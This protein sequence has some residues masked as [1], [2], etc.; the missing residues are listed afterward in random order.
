M[1]SPLVIDK[2]LFNAK[3]QGLK[4]QIRS[5]DES[6]SITEKLTTD[7]KARKDFGITIAPD[8]TRKFHGLSDRENEFITSETILCRYNFRYCADRYLYSQQDPGEGTSKGIDISVLWPSQERALR[9]IGERQEECYRELKRTAVDGAKGF[10]SGI[11]SAWHKT[12]QQGAT[13]F[14]RK[15]QAHRMIFKKFTRSIAASLDDVKKNEL[16]TRDKIWYDNL[17]FWFQYPLKYDVKATQLSLE[18]IESSI[19]YQQANQ[20][21]GVGT[22]Q[23]FDFVHMTE[24]GLWPN[25]WRLEFDLIPA[26]PNSVNTMLIWESTASGRGDD[27]FWYVFTENIRKKVAGYGSWLYIFT[28]C[29]INQSKNRLPAPDDWRPRE[30]TQDYARLVEETSQEWAGEK[31]IPT[32]HHLYWWEMEYARNDEQGTLAI[33]F[34]NFPNTPE[35][36]FQYNA[37]SALPVRVIESMRSKS[38]LGMPYDLTFRQQNRIAI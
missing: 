13:D 5:V 14:A 4:F 15:L 37:Q 18:N 25:A 10:T 20:Q 17:P 34:S 22:S 38:M 28:P 9:L 19:T 11:R 23:Q 7:V 30:E 21:S 12:R 2:L 31:I 8:G 27:N 33:F 16:Y 24:V 36:S 6:R 1:Y 3:K 32:R 35:Q 29:Y 26:I